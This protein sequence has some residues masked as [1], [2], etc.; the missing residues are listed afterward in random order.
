MVAA[1]AAQ[2]GHKRGKRRRNGV[3]ASRCFFLRWWARQIPRFDDD[4]AFADKSARQRRQPKCGTD[5]PWQRSADRP[6]SPIDPQLADDIGRI[7][8]GSVDLDAQITPFG[9]AQRTAASRRVAAHI[10][11]DRM[12][13]ACRAQVDGAGQA[14]A[15][16]RPADGPKRRL[17]HRLC[18][19]RHRRPRDQRTPRRPQ[20]LWLLSRKVSRLPETGASPVLATASDDA[21]VQ[22]A[23][24]ADRLPTPALPECHQQ[25]QPPKTVQSPARHAV[26]RSLYQPPASRKKHF[27]RVLLR[28][29]GLLSMCCGLDTTEW[30]QNPQIFAYFHAAFAIV[31]PKSGP[32]VVASG[33]HGFGR[34]W[35][36]R[37]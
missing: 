29:L 16:A 33:L 35:T 22:R 31:R 37:L 17:R 26:A 4:I 5:P 21:Q 18:D 10:R 11:A 20:R 9:M 28:L 15:L 36:W 3:A 19:A 14:A 2:L 8:G 32:A 27:Y 30:G 12:A 13:A 7:A 34:R 24:R 6:A 1:A 25:E 23:D